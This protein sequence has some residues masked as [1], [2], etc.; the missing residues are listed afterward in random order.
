MSRSNLMGKT[1]FPD[2]PQQKLFFGQPYPPTF[3]DNVLKSVFL[4]V[5]QRK[6]TRLKTLKTAKSETIQPNGMLQNPYNP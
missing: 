3:W 1:P 6:F 4:K 2:F 5:S